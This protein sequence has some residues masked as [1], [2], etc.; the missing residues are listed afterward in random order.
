MEL[1]KLETNLLRQ[2]VYSLVRNNL[3]QILEYV[4]ESDLEY[5]AVE[6]EELTNLIDIIFNIYE[7]IPTQDSKLLDFLMYFYEEAFTYIDEP[8]YFDPFIEC[9]KMAEIKS[10]DAQSVLDIACNNTKV[11]FNI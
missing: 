7:G 8:P 5:C 1:D 6:V 3:G 2:A 11:L 10:T 9:L 4:K